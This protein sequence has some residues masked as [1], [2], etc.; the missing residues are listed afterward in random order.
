MV[1]MG[2]SR[3]EFDRIGKLALGGV[4]GLAV[5]FIL[6]PHILALLA[7]DPNPTEWGKQGSIHFLYGYFF[8]TRLYRHLPE[9]GI[10]LACLLVHIWRRDYM[11]WPFPIIASLATF[12]I[13]CFI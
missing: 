1:Q 7:A 6:H 3:I 11:Q 13:G 5:Y 9:L 8:E 12:F 10:F 4:L 2:R